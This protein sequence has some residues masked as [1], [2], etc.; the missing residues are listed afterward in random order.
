MSLGCR[1]VKSIGSNSSSKHSK[2][3]PLLFNIVFILRTAIIISCSRP[4]GVSRD[5]FVQHVPVDDI[6]DNANDEKDSLSPF[7][8]PRD[9]NCDNDKWE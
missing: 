9:D 2:K 4:H 3:N 8:I 6:C 7:Y 1:D 5:R